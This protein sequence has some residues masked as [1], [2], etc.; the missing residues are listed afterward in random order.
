[1]SGLTLVEKILAQAAG[2][3]RV[4]AGDMITVRVD[5]AMAHDSSGPRRWRARLEELGIGLWDPDKVVLV[6]DH[7]VPAVDLDSAE[8]LRD[9]RAFAHEYGVRHVYDMQGI[10]HAILPERGHLRP[11][12]VGGGRGLPHAPCWSLWMLMPPASAPPT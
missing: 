4:A 9:F 10:C 12:M 8:I 7:Y 11:G 3:D 5:L 6:S 1:M 2:V